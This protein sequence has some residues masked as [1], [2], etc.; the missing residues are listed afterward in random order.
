VSSR[1]RIL[2]NGLASF[3][4][5]I[6]RIC[7]QIV[8]IPLFLSAWGPEYY[9]EWLT[10]M[11]IPTA[12]AFLD[13]GFGSAAANAMVLASSGGRDDDF[14]KYFYH[15]IVAI[16]VAIA[17]VFIVGLVTAVIAIRFDW[18]AGSVINTKEAAWAVALMLGA[19]A[20][21]FYQQLGEGLFISKRLA[22]LGMNLHACHAF[23][24]ILVSAC[25]IFLY[26][27]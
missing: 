13:L 4:Q 2:K 23:I 22:H 10:L 25:Y 15:G 7:D 1:N 26:R 24:N 16:S 20:L 11:A 18:L 19:R 21:A 8:L 14:R 17:T 12:L 6:L 9:G 27:L 5:K 3:V